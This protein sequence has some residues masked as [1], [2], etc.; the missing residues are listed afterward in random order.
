[1]KYLLSAIFWICVLFVTATNAQELK[2]GV[3]DPPR[4]APDFSL[5]SSM[6]DTFTLSEHKNQLII[7]GFGFTN[8]PQICPTTLAKLAQVFK[9]LGPQAADVQALYITV[10]PERDNVDRLREYM[11]HFNS[12]FI[13][14]TGEPDVLTELRKSYG[15]I[16]SKKMHPD[17][18]Y[19]VHHSSYLYLIDQQGLLRALI[20]YGKGK[21][22]IVHDIKLL[23]AE[24]SSS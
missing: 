15:I 1:M 8:C 24:K 2:S 6:G 12:K 17:G 18:N 23:L 9:D 3:F 16:A 11:G 22:D 7:L 14:L 10:D 5:L 21:E 19:D 13:G 4:A 20:P